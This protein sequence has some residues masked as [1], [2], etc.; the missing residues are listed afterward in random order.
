[1]K[2]AVI[3]LLFVLLATSLFAGPF[4]L[5]WGMSLDEVKKHGKIVDDYVEYLDSSIGCFF[6]PNKR[7]S[8]FA[9]YLI[10]IGDV[11]QLMRIIAIGRDIDCKGYGN[12]IKNEYENI[13]ASLTK[14]YGKPLEEHT[15][16]EKTHVF[17]GHP[18]Y[19]MS[20]LRDGAVNY[21]TVWKTDDMIVYLL[22]QP[23]E[24]KYSGAYLRL[25]YISKLYYQYL[26]RL[27]SAEYSVF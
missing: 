19:W 8:S 11:E 9:E 14:T 24:T 13:K 18:E 1:M 3:V 25:E 22:I 5:E 26:E 4:G 12:E 20:M 21:Y 23:S 16:M 2:K 17:Y 10:Q 27:D 7:H 15:D 6:Q